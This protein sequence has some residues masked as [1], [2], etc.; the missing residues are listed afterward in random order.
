MVVGTQKCFRLS[1]IIFWWMNHGPK[2]VQP[3]CKL[4][5]PFPEP[6]VSKV[7]REKQHI[8]G[9]ASKW[10][11]EYMC[12]YFLG[13]SKGVWRFFCK[14][15][16][17]I[18]S[19]TACFWEDLGKKMCAVCMFFYIQFPKLHVLYLYGVLC[20]F[21]DTTCSFFNCINKK[22]FKLHMKHVLI[23]D[24]FLFKTVQSL[25]LISTKKKDNYIISKMQIWPKISTFKAF[26]PNKGSTVNQ[27]NK[28][29]WMKYTWDDLHSGL[30]DS[31]PS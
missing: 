27:K 13:L 9:M 10:I 15:P 8:S 16:V 20:S 6:T 18:A 4:V 21:D 12:L 5:G 2:K 3:I 19:E 22:T 30:L 17:Q 26:W 14:M 28:S 24:H 29:V 7:L 11:T 1:R 25:D 31:S 23:F